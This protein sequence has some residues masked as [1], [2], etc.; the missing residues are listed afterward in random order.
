MR[1]A[2]IPVTRPATTAA[3][4]PEAPSSSAGT[5]AT[6]GTV[7]EMT[8]FTVGSRDPPADDEV[9]RARPTQPTTTAT[10]TE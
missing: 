1:G 10:T 7:N 2:R 6:N 4:S 8:V 5:A 3:T 9:Q